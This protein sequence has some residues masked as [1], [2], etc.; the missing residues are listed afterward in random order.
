M[1]SRVKF[2]C[3][4]VLAMTALCAVTAA[5]ASAFSWW[6]EKTGG[7]EEVLKSGMR[8]TFDPAIT[9]SLPLVLKFG[10]DEIKC[11][12]GTYKEGFIEGPT[13]I[14]ATGIAYEGCTVVKPSGC[15]IEGG[16]IST[17]E[18]TGSISL[19]GSTVEFTFKPKSGTQFA[20]INTTGSGCSLGKLKAIGSIS[21]SVTKPKELTK[22]KAFDI[23]PAHSSL[24][25]AA[26][27][28]EPSGND[29]YSAER[30]WSAH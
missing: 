20:E 4:C 27:K 24:T 1:S 7:G 12:S 16:K 25:I 22:E 18:L 17:A 6:I 14:G 23:E 29:G 30:G 11:T 9:G 13:G 5:S 28:A 3:C 2:A 10:G 8:E 26:T 21:G 19:S 15:S